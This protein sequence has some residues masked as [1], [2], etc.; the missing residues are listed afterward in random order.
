MECD[1][2]NYMDV[3]RTITPGKRGSIR[4]LKE[5]GD[6]LVAVR[7]RKNTETNQMLT[8]IEIV[9]D[10]RPILPN[11]KSSKRFLKPQPH[12]ETPPYTDAQSPVN[13]Q[14]YVALKIYYKEIEY[15]NLIKST[16]GAWSK[17]MKM[18]VTHRNTV[19]R[20]GLVD[21]IV[22]GAVDMCEDVD[23]RSINSGAYI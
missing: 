13:A 21:R 10:Q 11:V 8:T 14:E 18:W 19:E 22:E 3:V 6:Q 23:L 12:A 2:G 17:K 16:G 9:V 7:Y 20:I 15:R 4:Y 5:W 1:K